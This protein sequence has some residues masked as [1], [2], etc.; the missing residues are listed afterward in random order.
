MQ[1]LKNFQ[2]KLS[3]AKKD[4]VAL[5]SPRRYARMLLERPIIKEDQMINIRNAGLGKS[6]SEAEM[7]SLQRALERGNIAS[8]PYYEQDLVFK[9]I[10]L[11]EINFESW[12][13]SDVV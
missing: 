7:V 3:N 13:Y 5:L 12:K 10:K 9:L 4:P 6:I 2:D 11:N 1:L 8:V